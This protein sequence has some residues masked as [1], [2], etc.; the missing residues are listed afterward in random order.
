MNTTQES[1]QIVQRRANL[2]ELRKLGIPDALLNYE[3]AKAAIAKIEKAQ[4]QG[5]RAFKEAIAAY[6][7]VPT[8]T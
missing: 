7:I 6:G 8:T 4:A 1:D 3:A 2:E 5:D